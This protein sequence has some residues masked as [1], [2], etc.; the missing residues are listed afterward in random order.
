[1]A[2]LAPTGSATYRRTT[3]PPHGTCCAARSPL[4]A[5]A[6]PTSP[7][8]A[9]TR[10]CEFAWPAAAACA[11]RSSISGSRSTSWASTTACSP[12]Q[13]RTTLMGSCGPCSPACPG[14]PTPPM[15]RTSCRH[16]PP[17]RM[18]TWAWAHRCR[19][20]EIGLGPT[21]RRRSSCAPARWPTPCV[22]SIASR[23][24]RR[25]GRGA[26]TSPCPP[27]CR[28]PR[29]SWPRI[30][31]LLRT[32]RRSSRGSGCCR[33]SSARPPRPRTPTP[34]P[35]RMPRWSP[36]STAQ[37]RCQAAQARRMARLIGR[38]RASRSATRRWRRRP[39]E[40][41]RFTR[42]SVLK[43]EPTRR[44]QDAP[45]RYPCGCSAWSTPSAGR[46]RHRRRPRPRLS[47]LGPRGPR[48][49]RA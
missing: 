36:R 21:R 1:M 38:T 13:P 34:M 27:C 10:T 26:P 8:S 46:S 17:R 28:Y 25:R 33:P 40:S 43:P 11:P 2:S 7:R 16:W 6:S 14:G 35:R 15:G 9:A 3:T 23:P 12:G 49:R 22:P 19:A 48:R 37:V 47:G 45:S 24:R 20:W 29:S 30:P 18:S 44:P 41:F 32:P 31:P 42:R 4:S 39:S 5:R